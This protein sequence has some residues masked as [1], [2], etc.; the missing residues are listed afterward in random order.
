M[1]NISELDTPQL[2]LPHPRTVELAVG[3]HGIRGG[4]SFSRRGLEREARLRF[5]AAVPLTRASVLCVGSMAR[6]RVGR[7]RVATNYK[8]QDQDEG[9]G[10]NSSSSSAAMD[11][12]LGVWR[13][14]LQLGQQ[15]SVSNEREMWESEWARGETAPRH[16]GVSAKRRLGK[17]LTMLVPRK[18]DGFQKLGRSDPR[19]STTVLAPS[20]DGRSLLVVEISFGPLVWW[21]P[22]LVPCLPSQPPSS[23]SQYPQLHSHSQPHGHTTISMDPS[24][25]RFFPNLRVAEA[26]GLNTGI[27]PRVPIPSV[28]Q[29]WA[30]PFRSSPDRK[31]RISVASFDPSGHVVYLAVYHGPQ[32]AGHK[33]PSPDGVNM[34]GGVVPWLV[35][36]A[37][38]HGLGL[39]ADAGHT[40]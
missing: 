35:P 2:N 16:R 20:G 12:V 4:N 1:G 40:G 37:R 33:P 29:T 6:C 21:S 11:N 31:T 19:A 28:P 38:P 23:S 5:V 32:L 27:K 17:S 18:E 26:P 22:L 24:P 3:L 34:P 13:P 30:V 36:L 7:G 14:D 25:T 9:V 15:P 8:S 10:S 39:A